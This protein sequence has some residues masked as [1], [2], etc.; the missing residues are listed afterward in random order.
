MTALPDYDGHYDVE[1]DGEV[2]DAEY[3]NG[4][5][6]RNN[7]IRWRGRQTKLLKS[8]AKGLKEALGKHRDSPAYRGEAACAAL[9]LARAAQERAARTEKRAAL[10]TACRFFHIA[11]GLDASMESRD[12]QFMSYWWTRFKPGP[13]RK[14]EA[15]VEAFLNVKAVRFQ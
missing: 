7:A 13:K 11:V 12:V 14:V 5:W 15:E 1:I 3:T 10:K 4:K 8:D 6:S 2:V 9:Q